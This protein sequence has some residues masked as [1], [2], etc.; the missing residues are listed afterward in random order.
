M[1]IKKLNFEFE[2]GDLVSFVSDPTNYPFVV[3]AY[4][5]TE[6]KVLYEISSVNSYKGV[7]RICEI[8]KWEGDMSQVQEEEN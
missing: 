2:E 4:Y 5:I 1:S 8:Q 6:G 3:T 7:H